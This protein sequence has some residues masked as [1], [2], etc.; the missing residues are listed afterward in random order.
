MTSIA[1]KLAR[2]PRNTQRLLR[3]RLGAGAAWI[4]VPFAAQQAIRLATNI[5][6]ARMLAPEMFGVMVIVNTLRTG[7][8]LMSDIGIGQSVVRSDN[9]G[10][11]EFLDTAWTLQ[12]LRGALLALACMIGAA[13]IAASMG[14]QDMT[15]ILLV[16]SSVF[17]LTGLQG[18]GLFLNQRAVK[19]RQ[20]ATYDIGCTIFQCAI[21]IVLAAIMP[22]VWALVWGLVISS[23]FS[24]LMSYAFR[25]LML[26]RLAWHPDHVREIFHFGKWLFAST[27]IYFAA[28]S[29]DK[30]YFSAKLPLVLVGIY[31]IARTFSDLLGQLAQRAASFLVFPKMA[32]LKEQ[33]KEQRNELADRLRGAR[34][35]A[36]ALLALG[37]SIAIAGSDAFFLLC[38]DARYHAAAFMLPFLLLGTWFGVLATFA[39]A[40]LMGCDRPATAAAGNAAKFATLAVGLPLAMAGGNLFVALL[41]LAAAEIARWL[42]LCGFLQREGLASVGIEAMLTLGMLILA[43]AL[44]LVAGA[45]GIV[46]DLAELWQ[47]GSSV[48]G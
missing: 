1:A 26:P 28:I 46:P 41:V 24:T 7:L 23:A 13:P 2:F 45:T 35:T 25:P 44:K 11:R 3:G 38:Y 27:A 36:L 10:D 9:A 5:A 22:S 40:T 8:E 14:N 48:H 12:L 15:P 21:T 17:V 29:T 39:E 31:S 19:L 32:M 4:A 20:R 16:A 43:V 47:L 30:I 6:L 18:P 33:L 42:L 34:I 37:M